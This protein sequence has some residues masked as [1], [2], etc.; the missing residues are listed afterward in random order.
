ML[1]RIAGSAPLIALAVTSVAACGSPAAESTSPDLASEAPEGAVIVETEKLI[2]SPN[3]GIEERRRLVVRGDADW[4]AL[5][6]EATSNIAPAPEPPAVDFG[7]EMVVVA[8]MG[9]RPSGGYSIEI[10]EVRRA[11]GRL[12]A[13]VVETSPG[14]G[15]FAT[16]A[17]T[18]PLVAV[19]VP[20]ADDV[21]FVDSE[22]TRDCE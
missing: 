4:R 13:S 19:R 20:R 14:P 12:Y 6:S 3:S 2:E 11:D 18:A 21:T 10:D 15:C 1:A 16:Q 17:L 9:R 5:W 7:T 22:A 8:A